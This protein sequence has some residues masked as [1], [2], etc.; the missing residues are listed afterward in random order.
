MA[1]IRFTFDDGS[2]LVA[3]VFDKDATRCFHILPYDIHFD[4]ENG[5]EANEK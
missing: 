1:E 3:Q 5:I 4:V 2:A